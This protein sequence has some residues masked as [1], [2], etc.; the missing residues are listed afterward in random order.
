MSTVHE[1]RG[2]E[3]IAE[4]TTDRSALEAPF[5]SVIVPVYNDPEGLRDTLDTLVDQTYERDRYEVL[6]VDNRS[7]DETRAVAADYASRHDNVFALDE[8]RRQSSYAARV[9]GIRRARG[10]VLAF[11]DADMTVDADW[12]ERAIERM[13]GDELDYMACNVE[14]YSEGEET[15]ASKF[16]RLSGFPIEQYVDD[17][18]F[19]P[20][21]CLLVRSEVV[22]EVGPFD[23][24][25]VSSGDR[26]F[27]Q[28]VHDAGFE[29]GYAEDVSMYHPTRTSLKSLAKKAIRIGRG[30]HQMRELY[31]E[32]Y[33]NSKLFVFHPGLYSP[34]L[35]RHVSR[36]VGEWDDLDPEEKL[37]FTLFSNGL[38]AARAYGTVRE[39][40]ERIVG[41]A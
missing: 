21:C 34:E 20:T 32:R 17:L 40:V 4:Q 26:E 30:K 14:L 38:K 29:M 23:V 12:L 2:P 6:V 1:I 35:P 41:K 11:M 22:D 18:H 8:R 28:R 15:L 31:P 36:S 5:V 33:G 37:R 39:A 9:R 7:L 25:F 3:R 10:D 13:D 16:N 19:A 24:R 27:G